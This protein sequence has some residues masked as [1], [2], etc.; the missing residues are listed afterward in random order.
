M[1]SSLKKAIINIALVILTTTTGFSAERD[2]T[3]TGPKLI[4]LIGADFRPGYVFPSHE[5]LK[6]TNQAQKRIN[7]T[8]SGHLKYGFKFSPYTRLG[9]IYPYAVQGIGIAYNTF[10]NASELGDPLAIYVFQTSRIVSITPDLSV[11]YEWNFGASFGWKKYN[12]ELNPM[13]RVVGSKTNA[14][15]HLGLLLNWQIAVNTHLRAGIGVSH[16]SNGNTSYPNAGV[17]TLGGYIGMTR[18]FNGHAHHK[19]QADIPRQN[20]FTPYITYDLIVY[21]ATR[22]KGISPE[23]EIPMLVP[24]VFGIAGLNFNPLYNF[25]PYFRAGVS[26]DFQYDESANIEAH[27]ANQYIPA[28]SKDLKFYRPP[29]NEQFSAGL[30]LRAEIVMPIFSINVGIGKNFL[31]KGE[32]TNSFYQTFVLKTNV[33]KNIFLHTGYQLYKFKKPNNLM[34]GLGFR[35]NAR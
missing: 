23:N 15:I 7:T 9:Q 19:P 31:C 17:N 1:N 27:I 21:G 2:S 24:G 3:A 30:S 33:T 11:D 26:L 16:Y 6:G 14:Y 25:N 28:E 8:L 32:D 18:F 13:N 22:K 29:F 20:G 4:H 5:F 35:F 10:F 12:E 34:L